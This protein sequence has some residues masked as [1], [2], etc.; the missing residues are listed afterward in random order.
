M[1][2]FFSVNSCLGIYSLGKHYRA[3]VLMGVRIV[4]ARQRRFENEGT[5]MSTTLL[6]RCPSGNPC[7]QR[8]NRAQKPTPAMRWTTL[9]VALVALLLMLNGASWLLHES[10]PAANELLVATCA[11]DSIASDETP[12]RMC[13]ETHRN[14]R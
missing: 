3:R 5:T 2:P 4:T 8:R 12:L 1:T 11:I 7:H 10:P 6:I 9:A 14:V 13:T